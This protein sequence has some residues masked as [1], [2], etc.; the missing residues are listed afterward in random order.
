VKN[1]IER[2]TDLSLV[3]GALTIGALPLLILLVCGGWGLLAQN[4]ESISVVPE[5]LAFT[6]GLYLSLPAG[7]LCLGVTFR[8]YFVTGV[9]K[10]RLAITASLGVLNVAIG[11][12]SWSWF[13]MV[14]AFVA[15]H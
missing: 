6:T 3:R 12:V 1:G 10:K 5:N 11:L 15:H 4:P 8:A 2:G 14:S 13:L 9:N 7:L